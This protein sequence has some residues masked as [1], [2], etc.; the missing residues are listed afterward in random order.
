MKDIPEL[1]PNRA[2]LIPRNS[3]FPDNQCQS[4]G[5]VIVLCGSEI[6][7]QSLSCA[8]YMHQVWPKTGLELLRALEDCRAKKHFVSHQ[9][10]YTPFSP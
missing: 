10:H 8:E 3:R 9:G 4:L 6:N 2:M 7:A 5:Q 1:T